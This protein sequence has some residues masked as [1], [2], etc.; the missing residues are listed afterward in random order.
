MWEFLTDLYDR[1][2]I[3]ILVVCRANITRSAYLAG[4]MRNYLKNHEL[5]PNMRIRI[6][7]AGL[8]TAGGDPAHSIMQLTA[9]HYGFN[10]R[11][12]S[13]RP[14]APRLI[15]KADVI[16]TM[17]QH[18]KHAIMNR[19]QEARSKTFRVTEYLKKGPRSLAEDII[20][21]TGMGKS[22][23]AQFIRT[24]HIETERIFDALANS[25]EENAIVQ[26]CPSPS[27]WWAQSPSPTLAGQQ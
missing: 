20:D 27:K 6:L 8:Q 25:Y 24:A 1:K 10:L 11:H 5:K 26:S 3:T 16:L 15:R 13:S 2:T 4:Y 17:E 7:S 21:P 19:F 23:Y 9:K 12:H 14:L 22:D 18:Q